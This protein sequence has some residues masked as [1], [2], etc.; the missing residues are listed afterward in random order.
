MELAA[1]CAL[2][3]ARLFLGWADRSQNVPGDELANGITRRFDPARRVEID[4]ENFQW[5]VLPEMLA[6]GEELYEDLAEIKRRRRA[7]PADE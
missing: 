6:A 2:R 3:H 1:Q 7:D 5:L 4:L